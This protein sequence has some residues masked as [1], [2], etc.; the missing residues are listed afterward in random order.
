M[1]FATVTKPTVYNNVQFTPPKEEIWYRSKHAG[2]C[3]HSDIA[4]R[5]GKRF[6]FRFKLSLAYFTSQKGPGY[7]ATLY[8]NG[9]IVHYRELKAGNY[10]RAINIAHA[11]RQAWAWVETLNLGA[12]NES[13]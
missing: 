1:K 5:G 3:T 8:K 2:R 4:F 9:V 11:E 12:T 10:I 7:S 6:P 13:S